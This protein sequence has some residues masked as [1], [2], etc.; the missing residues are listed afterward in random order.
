M[1][2][3][4]M[5]TTIEGGK[6]RAP[7]R[8]DRTAVLLRKM[9]RK[10]VRDKV[11]SDALHSRIAG[12]LQ[13][14]VGNGAIKWHLEK[15]KRPADPRITVTY[16]VGRKG[17]VKPI[18]RAFVVATD[19]QVARIVP[20]ETMCAVILITPEMRDERIAERISA[21]FNN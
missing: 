20:R 6:R 9:E 7:H 21:L 19:Q 16:L 15:G 2:D 11:L 8:R 5:T 1:A 13:R 17:T 14:L 12:V 18:E 10:A 4:T 3:Q